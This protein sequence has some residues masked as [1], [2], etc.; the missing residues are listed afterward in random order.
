MSSPYKNLGDLS[1]V[2][3]W[4]KVSLHCDKCMV[5]WLGCMDAAECPQCGNTDAWDELMVA[6][7]YYTKE[8]SAKKPID[9]SQH[10]A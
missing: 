6:R 9:P 5:E 1:A 7:G 3:P 10:S 4:A 2:E 8:D